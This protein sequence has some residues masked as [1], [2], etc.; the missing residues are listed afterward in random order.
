MMRIINILL[1]IIA[2]E[3]T[4]LIYEFLPLRRML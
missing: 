2:V 3:L 4:A 1:I